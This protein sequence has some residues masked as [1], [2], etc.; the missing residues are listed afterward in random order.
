MSLIPEITVE[1]LRQWQVDKYPHVILD[2]REITEVQVSHFDE[3]THIPMAFCLTRQVEIPRNLP[4]VVHC[5]S[6]ARSAATVSALMSK[7]GFDNLF[8]LVGG[9]T[10]WAKLMAPE[11]EVG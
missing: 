11:L 5:R 7:H 3:M 9:F 6:G 4:V 2:I 10:A 1:A 8:N